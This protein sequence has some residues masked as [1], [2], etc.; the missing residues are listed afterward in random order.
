MDALSNLSML[1]NMPKDT[2]SSAVGFFVSDLVLDRDKFTCKNLNKMINK[3]Y[4]MDQI[5]MFIDKRV[6]ESSP[7]F[8]ISKENLILKINTFFTDLLNEST[9]SS[10]INSLSIF[11]NCGTI[12]EFIKYRVIEVKS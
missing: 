3:E 4:I 10:A 5:R 8:N 1:M 7:H 2:I 12:D 6:T 11:Y 9:W